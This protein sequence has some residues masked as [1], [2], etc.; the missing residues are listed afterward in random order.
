MIEL[1]LITIATYKIVAEVCQGNDIN[2]QV[3]EVLE[4]KYVSSLK[5]Q[6]IASLY[7]NASVFQQDDTVKLLTFVKKKKL[8]AGGKKAGINFGFPK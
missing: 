6:L 3:V 4:I 8:G 2:L 1:P 7:V 5:Y